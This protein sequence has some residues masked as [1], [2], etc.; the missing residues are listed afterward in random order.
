MSCT[1]RPFRIRT[2]Q[3]GLRISGVTVIRGGAFSRWLATLTDESLL[4]SDVD[5]IEAALDAH[6]V[7]FDKRLSEEGTLPPLTL[8]QLAWSYVALPT[9]GLLGSMY[10]FVGLASTHRL[11]VVAL[12]EAFASILCLA[13]GR[14]VQLKPLAWAWIGFSLIV[15]AA[16]G[17]LEIVS[18]L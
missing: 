1:P 14:V 16:V 5:R 18:L 6:A 15:L 13:A 11:S 8:M 10:A 9:V 12:G 17:V 3:N 2:I 4:S 7:L